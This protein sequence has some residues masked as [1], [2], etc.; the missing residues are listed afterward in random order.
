MISGSSRVEKNSTIF[1]TL[2]E[3]FERAYAQD[4]LNNYIL[5]W[6]SITAI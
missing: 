1:S 2:A 3:L 5:T 4:K 6:G